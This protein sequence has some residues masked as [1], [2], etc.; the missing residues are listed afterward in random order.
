MSKIDYHK[1]GLE[2]LKIINKIDRGI[3]PLC[4]IQ[5]LMSALFPYI[6]LFITSYIIDAII[7]KSFAKVPFLLVIL[8]CVN[9]VTGIIIDFLNNKNNYKANYVQRKMLMLIKKKALEI[10]YEFMEDADI[11]QKLSNAEYTM[12]HTMGYYGF[13]MYY[14]QLLEEIFKIITSISLVVTL[15]F[16]SA[17]VDNHMIN[18][19]VSAPVSLII[20]A[21]A[22][23]LNM[24]FNEMT[25]K[26]FN[27]VNVELHKK[28]MLVERR[29]NYYTG[30]VFLNYS[31][32]KDIRIFNMF[33][34]I[35]DNY[36]K[37]MQEAKDFYDMFYYKKSKNK[38]SLNIISNSIYTYI[39]YIIVILKIIAKSITIGELTKYIGSINIFNSSLIN[40]ININQRM[41]LQI[42]F[43]KVFNEFIKMESKKQTGSLLVEKN[44]VYDIEFH[45]VSFKYPNSEN[46]VLKN[47]S[48][49]L[50]EK[51]KVAVVGKNGAG[52]TTFIKLLCRLYDPT[53]GYISLNGIDI[54]EYDY[55]S[56]LSIFSVVFQDFNLFAF[57]ILENVAASRVADDE[58]VWNC[59][60]LSGIYEKIKKMPNKIETNLYR[61]DKDGIEVSGGEAQKIA[62]ARAL[63]KDSAFVILD[64]PTSALDPISEFEI[65]SKFNELVED[66]KSLFISHRMSSCR[67]CDDI[68]VF[69]DGKIVQRGDHNTLINDETNIYASLYN[70]Q[71]KY[72]K[73]NVDEVAI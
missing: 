52:K 41:K 15:C 35:H 13:I 33:Q 73:K 43:V 12:E 42:E 57:P 47:I 30:E 46:Y 19:I 22:T 31:M 26:K 8:I 44:D 32:G 27:T 49:K 25:A 63:Y 3:I 11:L 16:I 20:I 56:Y 66:K 65:Y 39:T 62:I 28:K 23:L 72:Y 36:K 67:F 48:C 71:A 29:F 4:L 21:S 50:I 53:E 9:F 10:D 38:E 1:S 55:E 60:K 2:S 69:D 7:S 5:S 24:K 45:N 61:Y 70:A 17:K 37:H 58:K 34:L 18:M 54:K 51:N 59:L 14:R 68:I 40:M 64:E 6:E